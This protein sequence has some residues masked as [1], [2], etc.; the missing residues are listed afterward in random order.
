MTT[1]G[2]AG[3]KTRAWL[4]TVINVL[5]TTAAALADA[6]GD[7]KALVERALAMY[8]L[9]RPIEIHGRTAMWRGNMPLAELE[10]VR[11]RLDRDPHPDSRPDTYFTE[12]I[13]VVVDGQGRARRELR[14]FDMGGPTERATR[15]R[16]VDGWRIIE[17]PEIGA[18][19]ALLADQRPAG[20]KDKGPDRSWS[21][22]M[23]GQIADSYL[24]RCR[25]A[26]WSLKAS[27]KGLDVR[28]LSHGRVMVYSREAG[29]RVLIS[30]STGEVESIEIALPGDRVVTIAAE[31]WFDEPRFPA[32]H[33]KAVQS[34]VSDAT[35]E[36]PLSADSPRH[37]FAPGGSRFVI[38]QVMLPER[39]EPA[40]FDWTGVARRVRD[41]HTGRVID[42]NGNVVGDRSTSP[43]GSVERIVRSTEEPVA[44]IVTP[45]LPVQASRLRWL[46]GGIGGVLFAA[47]AWLRLR[48]D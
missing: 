12:A 4:I 18:E 13:R 22:L 2:A 8:Q 11:G 31:G 3:P 5:M 9:D 30:E 26:L 48:R 17:V 45:G 24:H 6:G 43:D 35:S 32:R 34:R 28:H 36:V 23:L 39:V 41:H 20:A 16:I 27:E 33:P 46:L 10:V 44:G 42:A 1:R 37:E 38:D 47:A 15:V 40:L 21:D 14:S 19:V 7:G 29:V 25:H